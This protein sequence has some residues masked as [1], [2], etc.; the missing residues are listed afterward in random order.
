MN[1][2]DVMHLAVQSMLTQKDEEG[3]YT[4]PVWCGGRGGKIGSTGGLDMRRCADCERMER[5]AWELIRAYMAK[6]RDWGHADG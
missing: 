1:Q 3:R 6:M 4:L 5:K 2:P